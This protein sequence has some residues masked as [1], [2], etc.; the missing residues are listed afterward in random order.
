MMKR[1]ESS[2]LK[3]RSKNFLNNINF[4]FKL[5]LIKNAKHFLYAL[6]ISVAIGKLSAIVIFG[7]ILMIKILLD[8]FMEI[9]IK[10]FKAF[11]AVKRNISS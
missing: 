8:V 10:A 4:R 9:Q 7:R 11:G 5:L 3:E 2:T 1:I 6:V